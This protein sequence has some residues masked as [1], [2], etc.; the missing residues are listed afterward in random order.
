V[1]AA[2]TISQARV[3]TLAHCIACLKYGHHAPLYSK[4]M[5]RIVAEREK[6][7][8]P[9]E[10]TIDRALKDR[11]GYSR[12]NTVANA[13]F[14]LGRIGGLKVE[15]YLSELLKQHANPDDYYDLRWYRIAAYSYA[16]CAGP[17]AV[18]DLT[19][20]FEKMPHNKEK[21]DRAFLLVA[22]AMT[23]SGRGVAYALDH[24]DLLLHQM[25]AKVAQ[26]TAGALVFGDD[27]EALR[28][29]PAYRDCLLVGRVSVA[30]P[31]PNDYN[32]EFFWT[33]ATERG[34]RPI[35]EIEAAWK[36]DSA[37]IR[38]HWAD[39]LAAK[40]SRE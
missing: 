33:E 39:K 35:E 38:K 1:G 25:E 15:V 30:A 17:R 16:R 28:K 26:A 23:G 6:A 40:S 36:K 29:I 27:P 7:V 34:L 8:E 31:R 10:A 4:I 13:T 3:N 18:D 22:L 12:G 14:C 32:S 9:L 24:M 19:A 11:D 20:L 37:S 5:P 21:D 2:I